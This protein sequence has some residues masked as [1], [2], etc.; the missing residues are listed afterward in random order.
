MA[1]RIPLRRMHRSGATNGQVVTW[2]DDDNAYVPANPSGGGTGGTG[3]DRRWTAGGSETTIDEFNDGVLDPAWTR[4][5]GTG[6]AVGNVDWLED[7]DVLSATHKAADTGNASHGMVQAI[8]TAPAAGDAWVT[9]LRLFGPPSS[10]YCIG[11]I[12]VSD[13][14]THGSGKQV[15]AELFSGSTTPQ[16]SG[17]SVAGSNWN[18]T[19][20]SVSTQSPIPV[21]GHPVFLRLVY[22]GSSQWRTDFS[23][24]DVEWLPG[25]SLVTQSS[26]TPAYV[27][28]YS[29]DAGSGTKSVASFD[30]L[31]RVAGIS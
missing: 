9:C 31:R 1:S 28:L 29:R 30:F 16:Q 19:S 14:T 25:L 18:N 23:P 12:I 10:N 6:A 8:G 4:V 26:F 3:N 20:A 24:D 5:D 15:M 2:S 11:G 13:G 27:G 22:K 21:I 7:A 17:Y